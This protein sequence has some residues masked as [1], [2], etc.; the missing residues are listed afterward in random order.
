MNP[1]R[2]LW[3]LSALFLVF[4]V[5]GSLSPAWAVT[6][7]NTDS[8]GVAIGGYDPAAYF[9]QGKSVKGSGA[10]TYSW[11][12]ATWHFTSGEHLEMFKSNPKKY[13]PQYGG[14]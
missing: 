3:C 4:T 2:I 1:S 10:F 11:M 8:R 14:Y 5:V 12:G 6:P 7:I 9:T 13:A